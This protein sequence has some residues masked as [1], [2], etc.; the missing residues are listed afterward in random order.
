VEQFKLKQFLPYDYYVKEITHS[1]DFVNRTN[2]TIQVQFKQTPKHH[3]CQA[4]RYYQREEPEQLDLKFMFENISCS[5]DTKL[6][7]DKII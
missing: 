1:T 2:K 7:F 6:C 5:F 4:I 3:V